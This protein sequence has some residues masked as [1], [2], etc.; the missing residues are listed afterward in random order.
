[1]NKNFRKILVIGAGPVVIGQSGEYDY[2]GTQ[3]IRV[4][5]QEGIQIVV[6]NSN[7]TTVMTD[8]GLADT[9]Y[10]EPLNGETVKKIIE[11]EKPDG[12]LATAG[13]KTG[14]EICLEL[15]Q[16]GY[17]DE[18]GTVLLGAQP[19]VIKSVRNAQALQTMLEDAKEP[20][21]PTA[22]VSSETEAFTFAEEVGFP[23]SC[24]SAFS[25]E[26]G[27]FVRCND[28]KELSACF[29]S[30][31][32]KSLVGQVMLEKCVEGYKEIAFA[33]VRDACDNC[34]SVCS[35]ENIDTVGVHSGDSIVVLPA[36]TLTDAQTSKLRRAARKLARFLKIEGACLVRFAV[37]PETGKY[38]VLGVE[39]QL[40]RTTALISKITGYP[41]AAVCAKIALGYKL[42]EIKNEITGVTTAANEPAIDY[43][44]VKVPKWSFEN[45]GGNASRKLGETMQAT[46]EAFAVG[47]S[48]ELA[49]LKA[50]R[51]MNPKTE[52]IALPK[53]RLNTDGE[54][55]ELLHSR[56]N[57]RIFAVYEAIKRGKSLA[58]IREITKIDM[59][60]LSKL[61]NI[62][63]TELQLRAGYS[64][65]AYLYAKS[66]GFLDSVI[67]KLCDVDVLDKTS[68]SS[69]NTIDTC[70][71]EFDVQ[72]PYFY[73]AWDEDNEAAM[74]LDA[75]PCE[76]KK[77]LVVGAGPTSIGL[78]ADR[79]YAAYQALRTLEDFGFETVMLN[80]N[81]AANTTDFSAADKLYVDPITEE[82]VVNVAA[83]EHP[84][85]SILVFGGGEALRKSDALQNMGVTVYGADSA[86]HKTLKNKIEFFDILDRLNIRHTGSRR[87]L[88]GKGVEVDVLTD[89]ED[90]LI[91]GIY[92]HIEKAQ[93]HSG[94]SICVYPT[95]SLSEAVKEEVVDFTGK[96]V[97]E[98]KVKGLLNIQFVVY[99]NEVYVTS[100]SAVA[101]RNIPFM[102]K[103]TA[104][105]IVEFAVRLMLGESLRDIGVG[106]G[107]Y[108]ESEK[109]FV[110]VP[111]FSFESLEGTDVQLGSEMKSTGE[112]MGVADTFDEAL[113]KGFIASGMR[114]KRTGGVL[115]S[116]ADTDKQASVALADAFLKQDFKIYATSNTAKLLNANHVAS[117]AVRK[118]HEGEPNTL[119]L[120]LKKRLSYLVS[121]AEQGPKVNGDDVRIRRTAL[122]RRIPVL[123]SV[124]TAAALAQC[125]TD[126]D[127]VEEIRVQ[128]LS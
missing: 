105:P 51:S 64:E 110:R 111:V 79:D 90:F 17:L 108:K 77:I 4:L 100:A 74:F 76:K 11:I 72:K 18:H 2:A 120:I 48:F 20:Y 126:N 87:V 70:A 44:A 25:P 96:L 34:I 27:A 119:T 125:L 45:F 93:V 106:T 113:L 116:V 56:D 107:L 112:V 6:V 9:V 85:G 123:P 84:D 12:I 118:I 40:N 53:L 66:L 28:V 30:C 109:Y 82:D 10:I 99:D 24:K 67:A 58:E 14:L 117:N 3:M 92:E 38:I 61:K 95:V 91:P 63:D 15:S 89:G 41:I 33:C 37:H 80:N 31:A 16:N 26:G 128:K 102:S 8:R 32:D 23:V 54:I 43:C 5:K 29:E 122:L 1:M 52:F 101:T 86:V 36:Q 127:I 83:T 55:E 39:P 35:S 115:I 22:I 60:Y 71:A 65:E 62:A 104:L 75:H 68:H 47:T 103:A 121:T 59:Y 69:Y 88:I 42:F 97:R 73:S 19:E 114:I 98:L 94:D 46:G 13:G 7:P 81:P 50:I 21:L 49:F 124:E 57:E 78:G